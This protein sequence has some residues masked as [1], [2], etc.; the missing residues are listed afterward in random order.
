MLA[1]ALPPD[2]YG[3]ATA[4]LAHADEAVLVDRSAPAPG[5]TLPPAL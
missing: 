4:R 5:E 3:T 1:H 2:A